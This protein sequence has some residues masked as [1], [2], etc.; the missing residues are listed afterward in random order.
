MKI[1]ISVE[2][3]EDIGLIPSSLDAALRAV[4][5]MYVFSKGADAY[6]E[7]A[8]ALAQ[9]RIYREAGVNEETLTLMVEEDALHH[10]LHLRYSLG[11]NIRKRFRR[12]N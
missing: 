1:E 11:S 8:F 3:A 4:E 10:A 6:F 5:G 7:R 2:F 12:R 9:A